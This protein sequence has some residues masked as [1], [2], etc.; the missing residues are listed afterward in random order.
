MQEELLSATYGDDVLRLDKC[1]VVMDDSGQCIWRGPRVRMGMCQDVPQ[2]VVP[3]STSG[4]ADYFGSAVNRYKPLCAELAG[5]MRLQ[6]MNVLQH[7]SCMHLT[8]SLLLISKLQV[9]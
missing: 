8:S 2:T 1:G 7:T 6:V 9:H 5:L 3:H 4:R